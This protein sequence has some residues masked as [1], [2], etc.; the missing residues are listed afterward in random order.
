M[1]LFYLINEPYP[2]YQLGYRNAIEKLINSG[3]IEDCFFYSF[4]VKYKVEFNSDVKLF[5]NDLENQ[6]IQFKPT[7]ILF[8]H[9]ASLFFSNYF[10][11]QIEASLGYKPVYAL[12][13]RDVYGRIGKR[14]PKELLFLSQ[15]CDIVFLVTSGGWMYNEF[16]KNVKGELIYLPHVCDDFYFKNDIPQ[17]GNKKYDIVMIGNLAKSKI[18]FASMPGVFER[19]NVAEQMYKRY[20]NKFAVFGNGWEKYPFA[21]GHISFFEQ[22]K[23][24]KESHL[25]IG[26]DHFFSY[27]QYFSDR[28][29][30][31]LFSGTPHLSLLTPDTNFLFEEEKHIFYFKNVKDALMQTDRILSGKINNMHDILSN[32]KNLIAE[33]YM[34]K[35]RMKKLVNCIKELILHS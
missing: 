13:E 1:R 29:P 5:E 15:K 10:F 4:Q 30:I 34:E 16:K 7:A 35:I 12:D 18:P 6:I 8:A 32:A 28:L 24:L 19:I 2:D 26:I 17:S 20:G 23:V 3:D 33:K 14:L 31:A 21:A 22:D 27:R 9:T 25:S 11:F